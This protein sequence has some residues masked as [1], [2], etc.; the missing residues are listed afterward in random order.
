MFG[1]TL[2]LPMYRCLSPSFTNVDCDLSA[3]SVADFI[4]PDCSW[5]ISLL[6][7]IFSTD[8]MTNIISLPLAHGNWSDQLGWAFLSCPKSGT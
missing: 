7:C 1:L 6:S 8:M 3:Y 4:L 2:R 5:S